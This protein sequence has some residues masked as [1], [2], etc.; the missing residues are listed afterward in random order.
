VEKGDANRF[1]FESGELLYV[2]AAEG[3][4]QKVEGRKAGRQV[5][6]DFK[7]AKRCN[8]LLWLD[9]TGLCQRQK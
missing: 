9:Q 7:A 2:A 5:G 3:R 1:N 6:K 4:R 8:L